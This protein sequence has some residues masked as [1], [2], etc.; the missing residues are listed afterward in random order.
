MKYKELNK[1]KE[2]LKPTMLPDDQNE[3]ER[4]RF[5]TFNSLEEEINQREDC[6][7][8][9]LLSKMKQPKRKGESKSNAPWEEEDKDICLDE[10]CDRV[11]KGESLRK[12]LKDK[13]LPDKNTFYRWV[14]N[15]AEMLEQYA[16]ARE[17]R[18]DFLFEEILEIADET[19][20]DFETNDLGQE[21]V[22]NEAIQRSRLRI[23]SRKWMLGKLD[24]KK[25][26]DK[27]QQE[28]S[29]EIKGEVTVFKL[30][31]NARD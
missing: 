31:D 27:L 23:D 7:P 4:K 3:E 24:S 14:D 30:P 21:R 2:G 12:V 1:K 26:G 17:E 28:H 16:R 20:N 22:N 25:Y 29:G 9:K 15:S 19:T 10:I 8:K 5:I 13:H 18:N 11:S 6:Y